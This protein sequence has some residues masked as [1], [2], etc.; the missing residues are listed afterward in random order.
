MFQD[1][2]HSQMLNASYI[3]NDNAMVISVPGF[4]GAGVGI[5]GNF[6]ISDLVLKDLSGDMV[7]DLENFYNSVDSESSIKNWFSVPLIFVGFPVNEGRINIYLKTQMH[8]TFGFNSGALKFFDSGNFPLNYKSYNT[9]NMYFTGLD[10]RELAVGYAK[11]INE[12]INFGIRGK[13]LFGTIYAEAENWN[14]GIN[15]TEGGDEVELYSKGSGRVSLPVPLELDVENRILRLVGDNALGEY[16]GAFQ[17]PGFALDFGS[18]VVLNDKSWLSVA[19][20]DLGGIWFRKNASKIEQDA[21]Y[22]FR[23]FD[24]SNSIETIGSE[25]Y[26][27]PLDLMINT[28]DSIRNVYR[29]VVDTAGFVQSLTP[30]M[31]WHYQY[32]ISNDLSVGITNQTAFYRNSITN[33]ITVSTLQKSGN[34]SFFENINLYGFNTITV[35]G[36]IQFEGKYLQLFALTDNLFAVNHPAKNKSFSMVVGICALLN[37]PMKNKISDGKFSPHLPFHKIIK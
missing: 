21:T 5:D 28:K 6:K 1:N 18:T 12:K 19:V 17:N 8:T 37:K 16:L 36:G 14:Y 34:F 13:L 4:A 29:P 33:I 15:T 9:G 2:F 11:S 3:R 10:Y 32:N 7:V 22:T 31:A 20:N 23:G 27:D 30:K 25:Q 35:G 24:I 26:I